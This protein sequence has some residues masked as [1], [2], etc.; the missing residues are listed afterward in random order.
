MFAETTS[1]SGDE[2]SKLNAISSQVALAREKVK[3]SLDYWVWY[4][5]VLLSAQKSKTT[6]NQLIS[7]ENR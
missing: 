5:G 4:W 7:Y 6:N 2:V 1:F 3:F